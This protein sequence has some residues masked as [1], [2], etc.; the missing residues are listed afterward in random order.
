MVMVMTTAVSVALIAHAAQFSI[1]W[2]VETGEGRLPILVCSLQC[3][4]HL[5]SPRRPASTSRA[6][7]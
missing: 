5:S 3:I 6:D 4:S 7:V 2:R 1:R